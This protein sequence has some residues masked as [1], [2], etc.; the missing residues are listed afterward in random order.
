MFI[1]R[2][3]AHVPFLEPS[4]YPPFCF[5]GKCRWDFSNNL[6]IFHIFGWFIFNFCRNRQICHG[7]F[8]RLLFFLPYSLPIFWEIGFL[9]LFT[10]QL[11]LSDETF[12]TDVLPIIQLDI[13]S[14]AHRHFL[15]VHRHLTDL[16]LAYFLN[17]NYCHYYHHNH[18]HRNRRHH[19]HR[20]HH[21]YYNH[22]RHHIHHRHHRIVIVIITLVNS[23]NIFCLKLAILY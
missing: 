16:F 13:C 19:S 5:R 6:I 10:L 3:Y 9:L 7:I 15:L 17:Y 8:L 14:C 4:S 22:R 21:R 18:H 1:Y 12:G 23:Q 11:V 2:Y 20:H